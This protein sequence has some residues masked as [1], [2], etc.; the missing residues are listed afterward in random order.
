MSELTAI[1]IL[2]VVIIVA[3]MKLGIIIKRVKLITT[4]DNYTKVEKAAHIFSERLNEI[5]HF[6][7]LF[8]EFYNL[9]NSLFTKKTW[10][11]YVFEDSGFRM[12]KFDTSRTE[13]NLPEEIKK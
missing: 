4:G 5:S 12:I 6:H 11:F 8:P 13:D 9:F 3:Q 1:A 10:L 7:E 2:I